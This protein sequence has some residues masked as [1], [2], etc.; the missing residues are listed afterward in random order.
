MSKKIN[1]TFGSITQLG[2]E[3]S[4]NTDAIIDFPIFEGHVF[5]VCD[6]HNGEEGHG[7]LA[8]K[9]AA[10]SIKKYFYN[11]SYKDMLSALTNAVSF[12]NYAVYSQAQKDDKYKNIGTTLAILIF[13]N[14]KI[15]YAYAG[16][17]RIYL[18]KN[19]QLKALTLDHVED[20][21]NPS[22]SDV[23]VLIGKHKDIKFGVCKN[24]L[25]VSP[26]DY[27][28]ICTDGLS[29]V[30]GNQEITSIIGDKD[31]SPDHKALLLAQKVEEKQ[32]KDNIS[33]YVLEF[34]DKIAEEKSEPT[35]K[36]IKVLL[37]TI[38]GILIVLGVVF[39]IKFFKNNDNQKEIQ[40]Q[41]Q[42]ASEKEEIFATEDLVTEDTVL[43]EVPEAI[44]SEPE[45]IEK[46]VKIKKEEIIQEK[47]ADE[48]HPVFFQHKIQYGENLYRISL[49]YG[50]S[51]QKIIDLNGDF[52]KKFIAGKTI[53]IPVKAIHIVRKGESYSI[54]SD[55]Y[56]VK[57]AS[58]C[59]ANQFDKNQSLSEGVKMVIPF[60]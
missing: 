25:Q 33:A 36:S 48:T 50:V 12:A 14:Q 57:I 13:K 16:D 15:Y 17:S 22:T 9:L 58:I 23:N 29:D 27:F 42:A 10:E 8:A 35:K 54:L 45:K 5:L 26:D 43:E 31:T 51:Q 2:N 40:T 19:E 11:K 39:G 32:G 1:Y 20:R 4:F 37:F 7:A 49:R 24:P 21:Y 41:A 28:L 55:K 53:K 6:G 34:S 46:K 30:L 18:Y 60:R 44:Q 3:Q 47:I 59:R 56:N 52:A 38:L